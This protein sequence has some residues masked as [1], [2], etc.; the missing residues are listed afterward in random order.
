MNKAETPLLTWSAVQVARPAMVVCLCCRGWVGVR[1][2][3][4]FFQ[5]SPEL[6]HARW[7]RLGVSHRKRAPEPG[8]FSL[9]LVQFFEGLSFPA[10]KLCPYFCPHECGQKYGQSHLPP[11]LR[12]PWGYRRIPLW[13]FVRPQGSTGPHRRHRTPGATRATRT[14]QRR[15]WE[16]AH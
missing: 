12:G 16:Y 11:R 2:E 3:G 6:A 15:T 5:V 9:L 1:P 4:I 10:R 13:G 7:N 8:L 14:A